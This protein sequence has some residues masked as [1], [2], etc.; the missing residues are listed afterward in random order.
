MSWEF[1]H[2]NGPIGTDVVV[3]V[4]GDAGDD[5]RRRGSRG[6]RGSGRV[7]RTGRR[8]AGGGG[9]AQSWHAGHIL[10]HF[11]DSGLSSAVV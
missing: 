9:I 2:S 6:R 11:R 7:R 8:A 10:L 4:V 5:G 1:F 3:V